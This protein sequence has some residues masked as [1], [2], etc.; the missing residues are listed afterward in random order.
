MVIFPKR[1]SLL[2]D[3][4]FRILWSLS[5]FS[6]KLTCAGVS[7]KVENHTPN[8]YTLSLAHSIGFEEGGGGGGARGGVISELLQ[9]PIYRASV[10]FVIDFKTRDQGKSV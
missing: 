6:Q 10:F 2:A 4:L 1:V 9:E 5:I 3:Q 8:A 7:S